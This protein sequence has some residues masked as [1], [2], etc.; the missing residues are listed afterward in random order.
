MRL[1]MIDCMDKYVSIFKN[2]VLK[3]LNMHTNQGRNKYA[4]YGYTHGP[5]TGS[6]P[7]VVTLL[8]RSCLVL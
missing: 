1:L 7:S 6:G 8:L 4:I 3:H 5:V 2:Y